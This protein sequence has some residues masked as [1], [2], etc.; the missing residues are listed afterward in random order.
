MSINKKLP[1]AETLEKFVQ[2]YFEMCF[3]DA[4]GNITERY[5]DQNLITL[6]AYKQLLSVIA[7]NK[8]N[9]CL[10]YLVLGTDG[11][12]PDDTPKGD[13]EGFNINLQDIFSI[14]NSKPYYKVSWEKAGGA[15]DKTLQNIEG[16]LQ[17]VVGVQD[18]VT[19]IEAQ[20]YYDRAVNR[21]F[22]N[23]FLPQDRANLVNNGSTNYSEAGLYF[24][25]NKIFSAKMF[26]PQS[27]TAN[28]GIR[29]TWSFKTIG[30]SA[31][32]I[33]FRINNKI[34]NT[35]EVTLPFEENLQPIIIDWG[36]GTDEVTVE[37]NQ[38]G[39]TLP[40]YKH[41]Y[42]T[43]G[44]FSIRV[45]GQRLPIFKFTGD[46]EPMKR[47]ITNIDLFNAQWQ[48]D[49]FNNMLEGCENLVSIPY[50][51]FRRNIDAENFNSTFKGCRSLR[52]LPKNLLEIQPILNTAESMFEGCTNLEGFP[53]IFS[54]NVLDDLATD[55]SK[56]QN[57]FKN[58]KPAIQMEF[59]A[60]E[61]NF[62]LPFEI[63]QNHMFIDWGDGST[64]L[65]KAFEG[66]K[67]T[68]YKH[69]YGNVADRVITVHSL[70]IPIINWSGDAELEKEHL[71]K[72][73]KANAPFGSES[74][75]SLAN[76]FKG[77][78]NL[79]TVP[80]TLL[81]SNIKVEDVSSIFEGCYN[82]EGKVMFSNNL[83]IKNFTKACWQCKKLTL[84]K[85]MI[86]KDCVREDT[87]FYGI[88]FRTEF[89][90]NNIGEFPVIWGA[91]WIGT[92]EDE[93]A[94][95]GE[96]NKT[97]PDYDDIP[98]LLKL[99]N[100]VMKLEITNK[101]LDIDL[102]LHNRRMVDWGDKTSGYGGKHSYFAPGTYEVRIYSAGEIT[103]WNTAGSDLPKVLKT[104]ERIGDVKLKTNHTFENCYLLES[105]P[106]DIFAT[107]TD[108]TEF[109]YTFAG[110]VKLKTELDFTANTKVTHFIRT[111]DE[112]RSLEK[113]P[114]GFLKDGV[115][116]YDFAFRNCDSLVD[117]S[118]QSGDLNVL[119]ASTVSI[120]GMFYECTNLKTIDA[121]FFN[122]DNRNTLKDYSY[123]FFMCRGLSTQ[124]DYNTVRACFADFNL[125]DKTLSRNF[126]YFMHL[127]RDGGV[128]FRFEAPEIYKLIEG[129]GLAFNAEAPIKS[130]YNAFAPRANIAN[131]T[132]VDKDEAWILDKFV[133]IPSQA[134]KV[135][136]LKRFKFVA[137]N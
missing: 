107:Y 54:E 133:G 59:S 48:T 117:I 58:T 20:L 87:I 11:V 45:I 3:V 2:G 89:L 137:D 136:L 63:N 82:L 96:G 19:P 134:E 56:V 5:S 130:A 97:L 27:K 93:L 52:V 95:G 92:K 128:N 67:N 43:F 36:D 127:S 116:H 73:T 103:E 108:A 47:M 106:A 129:G 10:S 125:W 109:K 64:T 110:C 29:I 31:D 13:A 112:C 62:T 8:D 114:L 32:G 121:T 18:G 61:V 72:I 26:A 120:Q 50:S 99:T 40:T 4:Q 126:D 75:K 55:A 42:P 41:E 25:N 102:K 46:A 39:I 51:L 115:T 65:I 104:I 123:A 98:D 9:N 34:T 119:P 101:T 76:M 131:L 37:A 111:F 83:H 28:K 23:V 15:E 60:R 57:I 132:T 22:F 17:N 77:C 94:F 21:V 53:D 90:G 35:K 79:T 105:V 68:N 88:F 1:K 70:S 12:K 44:E 71:T 6:S 7:G 135:A 30:D 84:T 113:L 80:D 81:S 124:L 14:Q 38:G 78:I 16:S 86:A 91:N 66:S 100:L 49:N 24:E 74:Q 85:D 33:E 118:S 122:I 69:T